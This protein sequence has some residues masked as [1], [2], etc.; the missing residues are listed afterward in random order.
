MTAEQLDFIER[1]ANAWREIRQWAKDAEDHPLIPTQPGGSWDGPGSTLDGAQAVVLWLPK[2]I[3]KLGIKT[4]LDAPCGDWTWMKHVDLFGVDY[5][6]WD[7][8]EVR[9][10]KCDNT[11]NTPRGSRARTTAKKV[12]FEEVNLLKVRDV[13][14]VDLIICRDFLSCLL[15][16]H[17]QHVLTRFKLSGSTWLLITTYP[18]ASNE[19]TYDPSQQTWDGY[20]ERP[21][22]LEGPPWNLEPVARVPEVSGPGGV[23]TMPRDMALFPLN[24]GAVWTDAS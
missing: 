8:D 12:R 1:Q 21:V 18:G 15:D 13:P 11:V 16:E 22:N 23:L 20:L 5:T 7:V 19:Y 17:I 2:L 9:I 6:G 4:I 3:T 24:H 10:E 14:K